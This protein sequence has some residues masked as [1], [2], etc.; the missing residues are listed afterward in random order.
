MA[1]IGKRLTNVFRM[2]PVTQVVEVWD[3]PGDVSIQQLIV[4][5]EQIAVC[6]VHG[7]LEW[8]ERR[9]SWHNKSFSKI[10]LNRLDAL[11][12]VAGR[13]LSNY[14]FTEAEMWL[15]SFFSRA[16]AGFICRIHIPKRVPMAISAQIWTAPNLTFDCG[17]VS[18]AY[19]IQLVMGLVQQRLLVA[20]ALNGYDSRVFP[21]SMLVAQ[22]CVTK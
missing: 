15:I 14:L 19:E 22:F 5:I 10:N 17:L 18:L 11:F 9:Q 16:Q 2:Y 20:L 6:E 4:R 7:N 8:T 1:G 12:F 21:I 13:C 3:L